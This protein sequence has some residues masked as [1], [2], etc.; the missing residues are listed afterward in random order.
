MLGRIRNIVKGIPV[1]GYVVRKAVGMVRTKRRGFPGSAEYWEARYKAGGT[2]GRGSYEDLAVW[3]SEIVNEFVQQQGV[4][5]VIDF[6]CGDG[7]QLSLASYPQ[8][9]GMDVSGT[10][11]ANCISRFAADHTKSFFLY[12]SRCFAD[13]ANV[14]QADLAL[15]LDV[16]FHLVEDGVFESYM[17]HLFCAARRFVIIYSSDFEYA[18]QW[19]TRRR[20]FTTWIRVNLPDWTLTKRIP[21]QF[22]VDASSRTG[23]H[24]DFYIYVRAIG[25]GKS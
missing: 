12:D 2:S 9:I 10:C 23:S 3:K 14:F 18:Q 5:S 21:N 7:N 17:R 8:Y 1:V 22:P 19:H 13:N 20:Q 25:E 6:G 11:I 16:L 15:S 24:S 4:Q